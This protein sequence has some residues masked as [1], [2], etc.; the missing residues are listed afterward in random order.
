MFREGDECLDAA[1]ERRG[2]EIAGGMP[3]IEW[4]VVID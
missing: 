2:G 3:Q 4:L 1:V